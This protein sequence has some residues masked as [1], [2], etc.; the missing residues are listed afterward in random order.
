MNDV[1]PWTFHR[2]VASTVVACATAVSVGCGTLSPEAKREEHAGL[3]R[4]NLCEETARILAPYTN[5]LSLADCMRIARE[6]SL[7]LTSARLAERVSQINAQAAFSAFLPQVTYEFQSLDFSEPVEKRFGPEPMEAQ[8]RRTRTGA[9]QITQPVFAPGAWLLYASARRGADIRGLARERA[10]QMLD[11][12]VLNLFYQHAVLVD[13]VESSR[14]QLESSEALLREST[15]LAQAGYLSDADRQRVLTLR[16]ARRQE[17]DTLERQVR[18]AEARLMEAMN[19]WPLAPA[20]F[21]AESLRDPAV[22]RVRMRNAGSPVVTL[23][24]AIVAARPVEE[25]ICDA[26]LNR[27]EMFGADRYIELRRNEILRAIALFLPSLYGF[28]NF[29]T[30]T[31]SYTVND[32]YWGSG[33]QGTLSIFAGFRNV[34]AY[35][36]A[37][38]ELR[39]AYAQREQLAMWMMVQVV[40]AHKNLQ[41]ATGQLDVARQAAETARLDL[42][43]AKGRFDEGLAEF[44]Q[45]LDALAA[46]EASAAAL[47]SAEYAQAATLLVFGDV[48]GL[49]RETGP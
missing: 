16:A 23:T 5:G 1:G 42:A 31:D 34:N 7:A 10:E 9:L 2:G 46:R 4:T 48:T 28:A 45:Y 33:L 37:R 26:L 17:I 14:R 38:A 41:D 21:S 18:L 8:D 44:S 29:Y 40:E 12:Q 27:P 20:A 39:Q 3:Y 32:E 25:W 24:P 6:R 19:L 43:L 22:R 30:T 15:A 47:R 35:R 11:T 49:S 13:R 36:V